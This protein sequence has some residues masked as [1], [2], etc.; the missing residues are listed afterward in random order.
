M[1][2]NGIRIV[3]IHSKEKWCYSFCN[4]IFVCLFVRFFF[5]FSVRNDGIVIG[6]RNGVLSN[7]AINFKSHVF[8]SVC[9][10]RETFQ[11]PFVIT[12]LPFPI[13]IVLSDIHRFMVLLLFW[14]NKNEWNANFEEKKRRAIAIKIAAGIGRINTLYMY[15]I[16]LLSDYTLIKIELA[17]MVGVLN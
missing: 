6:A 16:Y 11:A 15:N 10:C 12:A 4:L 17:E 5:F 13:Q 8:V 2:I 7:A 3:Q 1:N 14:H 9:L